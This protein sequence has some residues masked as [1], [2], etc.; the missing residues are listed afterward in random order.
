MLIFDPTCTNLLSEQAEPRTMFPITE[1]LVTEPT[2]NDECM[3]NPDPMRM[4]VRKLIEDPRWVALRMETWLPNRVC[5]RTEI[6]DPNR[7]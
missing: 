6:D 2:A 4:M 3:E 1:S 7:T 5:A